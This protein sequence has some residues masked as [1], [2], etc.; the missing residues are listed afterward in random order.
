M[1]VKPEKTGEKLLATLGGL[2]TDDEIVS[3]LVGV[4]ETILRLGGAIVEFSGSAI[5]KSGPLKGKRVELA[6]KIS[7]DEQNI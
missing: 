2:I 5:V 3:E 4:Q 1:S 7:D 6:L